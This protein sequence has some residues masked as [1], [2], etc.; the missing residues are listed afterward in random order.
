[1]PDKNEKER[2]KQIMDEI[3]RKE[4]EQFE[5]SLPMNRDK[6]KALFDYLDKQ[7]SEVDCDD[8]LK[9]TNL[10]LQSISVTNISEINKWL[11]ERSGYCDC[12][13]LAN[14]EEEFE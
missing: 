1:M 5:K 3:G 8:T 13:V 10:F 7:L 9:L 11:E 14:V 2:R 6:F 12:E 4:K